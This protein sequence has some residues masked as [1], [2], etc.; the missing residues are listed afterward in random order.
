MFA[1]NRWDNQ[2]IDS[3]SDSIVGYIGFRLEKKIQEFLM[4][5]SGP[6]PIRPS[7]QGIVTLHWLKQF[8]NDSKRVFR[9]K[10]RYLLNSTRRITHLT[11]SREPVK[12][13]L[14]VLFWGIVIEH[15]NQQR[16]APAVCW[17]QGDFHNV[18]EY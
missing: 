13:K 3:F 4:Q 8:Q 11:H 6:Q 12:K 14:K 1:G 9:P 10:D 17:K 7:L 15:I 2:T 5:I 16:Q 18:T